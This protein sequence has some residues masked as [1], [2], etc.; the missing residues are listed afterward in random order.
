V[1]P[2]NLRQTQAPASPTK[3]GGRRYIG[4]WND[5]DERVLNQ[6][7]TIFLS[8]PIDTDSVL[9]L[10]RLI[11]YLL[12]QSRK[13]AINLRINTPGGGVTDGLAIYDLLVACPA[14]IHAVTSGMC[15]SMGVIILQAATKREST[16]NTTFM[17]HELG[18]MQFGGSL[19]QSSNVQKESERL[20]QVLDNILMSRAGL[21]KKGI[22]HFM[23][24]QERYFGAGDALRHGLIDRII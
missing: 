8:G 1:A 15:M 9:I 22:A 11:T 7:R 24:M 13:K 21:N 2:Q 3:Q 10:T 6:D 16:P 5:V 19:T 23:Q 14:P 12:S 20:Q 17:L 18:S 4:L